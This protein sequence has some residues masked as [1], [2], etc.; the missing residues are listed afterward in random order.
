MLRINGAS[1]SRAC[2]IYYREVNAYMGLRRTWQKLCAMRGFLLYFLCF[3]FLCGVFWGQ[4]LQRHIAPDAELRSYLSS[5]LLLIGEEEEKTA[6]VLRLLA[7]YFRYP[8]FVLLA[9]L[10]MAGTVLI[11]VILGAQGFFLSF[12]LAC[13]ASALG[14]NG[15]W[16]GA[17]AFGFRCL[18]AVP[19]TLYLA[20][21]V[22]ERHGK[23]GRRE[24]RDVRSRSWRELVLC[25]LL[26]LFCAVLDHLLMPRLIMWI[27]S[28]TV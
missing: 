16:L 14:R 8:L 2:L 20:V 4:M 5:Y 11:P 19:C 12:S 21:W 13:F 22:M 25:M 10:S 23:C 1:K 6:D 18:V 3:F 9:G 17:A 27:L 28:K 24:R 15:I 26:L 7:A